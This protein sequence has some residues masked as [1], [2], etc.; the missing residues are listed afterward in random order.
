MQWAPLVCAL[1][2]G[3]SACAGVEEADVFRIPVTVRTASGPVTFQAE[4]ADSPAERARGLMNRTELADGHGMLFIFPRAAQQSFW[5]KNTFIPLDMIFI[6]P[7]RTI[8]GIVENA[9]PETLDAR[10]VPGLSQYVLEINGGQA[11][12]LGIASGQRVEFMA[13]GA[14]R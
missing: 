10:Q 9:E 11:A 13:P 14:E 6:R 1:V 7:D 4:I 2:L 5:M 3:G 12:E 8:L